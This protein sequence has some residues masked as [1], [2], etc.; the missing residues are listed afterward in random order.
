MERFLE[1]WVR[2]LHRGQALAT[3]DAKYIWEELFQA[4]LRHMREIVGKVWPYMLLGI[5]LGAL[6]HGYVPSDFMAGL[7]GTDAWW[8]VPAAVFLGVYP[9]TLTLRA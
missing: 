3:S 9:C 4:G 5:G 1:D 2:T 6:I 8:A 7:M